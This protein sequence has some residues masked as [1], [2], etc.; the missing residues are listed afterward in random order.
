[1]Y[2][3]SILITRRYKSDRNPLPDQNSKLKILASCERS[4]AFHSSF[5]PINTKKKKK[6]NCQDPSSDVQFGSSPAPSKPNR[7]P[8]HR[9]EKRAKMV[10]PSTRKRNSHS[11]ASNFT[12][13]FVLTRM[14]D[15]PRIDRSSTNRRGVREGGWRRGKYLAACTRFPPMSA[16]IAAAGTKQRRRGRDIAGLPALQRTILSLLSLSLRPTTVQ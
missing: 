16:R 9:P 14:C 11:T 3:T 2:I 4:S 1:M 12:A 15:G 5:C 8:N 13:R 7:T 10:S 6:K